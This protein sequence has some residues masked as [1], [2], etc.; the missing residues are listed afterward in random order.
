MASWYAIFFTVFQNQKILF[1]LTSHGK[2]CSLVGEPVS[3]ILLEEIGKCI[4]L[5]QTSVN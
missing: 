3:G 4:W 5:L 1:Q 2:Q